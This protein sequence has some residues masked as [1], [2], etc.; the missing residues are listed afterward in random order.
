[1]RYFTYALL[2][3]ALMCLASATGTYGGFLIGQTQITSR[4]MAGT[5][6]FV[7]APGAVPQSIFGC[8][9]TTDKAH[10]TAERGDIYV[11]PGVQTGTPSGDRVYVCLAGSTGAYAWVPVATAP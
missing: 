10:S 2:L 6:L 11:Q 8:T 1:M 7:G 4:Q 3:I 9:G 5:V